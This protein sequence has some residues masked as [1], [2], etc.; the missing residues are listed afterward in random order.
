MLLPQPPAFGGPS[1]S[2]GPAP[3]AMSDKQRRPRSTAPAP[4]TQPSGPV[5]PPMDNGVFAL[6]RRGNQA[7]KERLA[8]H[9]QREAA[10]PQASPAGPRRSA[11]AAAFEPAGLDEIRAELLDMVSHGNFTF[12]QLV[13]IVD[14]QPELD[15]QQRMALKEELRQRLQQ[16][17]GA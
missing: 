16:D 7:A 17:P 13:G 15:Q 10:G 3:R 11:A 5:R 12:L 14:M 8:A 9:Q 2:T 1:S 4:A 6:L